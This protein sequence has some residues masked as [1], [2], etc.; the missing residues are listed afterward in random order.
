MVTTNKLSN[1]K[2]VLQA[3]V[4]RLTNEIEEL[5]LEKEES[6]KNV[7][8]FMQEAD[9]A[10][11]EAKRALET[12]DQSTVLSSAWTRISNLDDTCLTQLLTLL[13]HHAVDEWAQLRS[14]HVSLQSTLDQTRDEVHATR[15]ALEEETKRANLMKK[16]WQ[17]A[18]YQLEKAE[19]IID[20][21]KMTQEKEIRQEY[22]SK[23]NQSEQSQLHWKNQCEK[24][25]SQNA[26]YEEQTKA[27][28]AKEI[29]LMLVNKTL[30]QEIRKLNREEREL[31]NLEYL[32]N[33]I[34]KFLERKNTRAQLVPILSTLLQ[35]SQEDQTRLFQLTQNTITS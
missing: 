8:H 1:N 16:R 30:K 12:L 6:K 7:L 20:S 5:Y 29:H 23:L 32:R 25:I 33:V 26:L 28:K 19:H 4:T 31:V 10:R 13:D 24:L 18:E 21:N 15:V 3:Q 14:D 22:Q 27:S 9:L 11:Q 2:K 17:N 34:L 35:C